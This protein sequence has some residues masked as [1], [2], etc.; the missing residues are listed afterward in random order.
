MLLLGPLLASSKLQQDLDLHAFP[1]RTVSTANLSP[2]AAATAS[3]VLLNPPPRTTRQSL[4]PPA[5][6]SPNT[7]KVQVALTRGWHVNTGQM[8]L[9][10]LR[11]I[12]DSPRSLMTPSDTWRTAEK[13][14][15]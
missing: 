3:S 15:Q 5:A 14:P 11:R 1:T 10:H 7:L 8:G 12:G 13:L 4:L 9:A 6:P 2:R